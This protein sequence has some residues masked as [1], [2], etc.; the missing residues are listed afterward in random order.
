MN[1]SS[2]TEAYQ[3]F[4]PHGNPDE[5]IFIERKDGRVISLKIIDSPFSHHK[6]YK[7]GDKIHYVG[8]GPLESHGRPSLGQTLSKQEPFLQTWKN[9]GVISI[10]YKKEGYVE[11]MGNYMIFN[12]VKCLSDKGFSYFHIILHRKDKN[13]I[14]SPPI[15]IGT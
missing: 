13:N 9:D 5:K 4:T 14:L 12:I 11:F 8:F 1:F 7:K 6:I 10:Y 3:I 15:S 2:F